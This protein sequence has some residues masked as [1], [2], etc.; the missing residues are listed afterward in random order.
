MYFIDV[1]LKTGTNLLLMAAYIERF[2]RFV[3][4]E[5]QSKMD[6]SF[7][8]YTVVAEARDEHKR[9]YIYIH[10]IWV[11][12]CETGDIKMHHVSLF[13]YNQGCG[14]ITRT[15][16][17]WKF[18]LGQTFCFSRDNNSFMRALWTPLPMGDT[19]TEQRFRQEYANGN[20]QAFNKESAGFFF[21]F[22]LTF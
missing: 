18:I 22:C 14:K 1:S 4:C 19:S 15:F 10:T 17:F 2:Q 6:R 13:M 7:N 11:F 3:D 20:H 5:A 12:G 9:W 21:F 8:G 16:L